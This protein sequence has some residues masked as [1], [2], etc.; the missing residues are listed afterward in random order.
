V[1]VCSALSLKGPVVRIRSSLLLVILCS[2]LTGCSL[3]GK[4]SSTPTAQR[5]NPPAAPARAAP[6]SKDWPAAE[7]VSTT[8]QGGGVFAGQVIDR[9][10]R[11]PGNV[12]IRVVDL[13][14]NREPKSAPIEKQTD[15]RGCFTIAGLR[16]G[17]HYQLI[18]RVQDGERLYSGSL[19]AKPPNPRLVIWVSEDAPNSG[20]PP[21]PQQPVYP[22]KPD[23]GPRP[24]AVLDTPTRDASPAASTQ[25]PAD[26]KTG[27]P[28]STRG[29]P[30]PAAPS[31]TIDPTRVAPIDP[32]AGGILRSPRSPPA[33]I[34]NPA[35][36][37][38]PP[39][40]P[41][42]VEPAIA[43]RSAPQVGVGTQL[44]DEP[45]PVPSCQLV[46]RKLVNLALYD[47]TGRVWE[48]KKDRAGRERIGRLVLLDFWSSRCAPC[49][50]AM[51]HLVELSHTYGPYGLDLVGIAYETGTAEQQIGQVL[52]VRGRYGI[53]YP[54]LL[55]AGINCPVRTQFDIQAFPTLILIDENGEI[56]FRKEGL[57][58]RDWQEL[59][60]EIHKRLLGRR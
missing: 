15:E 55:G 33:N 5:T 30:T 17:G 43:P 25:P 46:G 23:S 50:A 53:R 4:K 41:R 34:P 42:P 57:N 13:E 49:L 51:P 28:P 59:D 18:A 8:S 21:I 3:F 52:S 19:Y 60:S 11:R 16:P 54:T 31:D 44:S 26:Q 40:G 10:N 37:I 6:D 39:P 12:W 24:A 9:Y 32:D 38:P 2:C 20:T 14:D 22:G 47:H 27:A 56:V 58:A 35:E 7:T 36:S 45:V 1:S 48:F 29:T